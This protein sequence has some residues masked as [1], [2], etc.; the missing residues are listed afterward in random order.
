MASVQIPLHRHTIH[1]F[2][3]NKPLPGSMA[4]ATPK[5]APEYQ[6]GIDAVSDPSDSTRIGAGEYG[7]A[8]LNYYSSK[9]DSLLGLNATYRP[10]DVPQKV[11]DEFR[12][13]DDP[14]SFYRDFNKF[15]F[16]QITLETASSSPVPNTPLDSPQILT[17]GGDTEIEKENT[18]ALNRSFEI[19]DEMYVFLTQDKSMR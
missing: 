11:Q 9:E 8:P 12:L 19:V 7:Q 1:I 3:E 10:P 14:E 18:K 6:L 2:S 5:T 16:G 15:S 17:P 13:D 4:E